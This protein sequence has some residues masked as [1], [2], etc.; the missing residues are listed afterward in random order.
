MTLLDKLVVLDRF[1]SWRDAVKQHIKKR[2]TSSHIFQCSL[3]VG[4][5]HGCVGATCIKIE[6]N[7]LL[8][9]SHLSQTNEIFRVGI[10]NSMHSYCTWEMS[11][12]TY[13]TKLYWS[14]TL[15]SFSNGYSE[16]DW[17]IYYLINNNKTKIL[18]VLH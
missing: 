2:N 13:D 15:I 5:E 16:C 8:I 18:Q 9:M 3:R 1:N 14:L 6:L 10:I 12:A 11:Q 4:G 7:C 17:K